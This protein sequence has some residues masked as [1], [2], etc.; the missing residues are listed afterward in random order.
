MYHFKEYVF[1]SGNKVSGYAHQPCSVKTVLPDQDGKREAME[2]LHMGKTDSV[3]TWNS[4][5]LLWIIPFQF[6]VSHW[7]I[8]R[9][10]IWFVLK[11][12]SYFIVVFEEDDSLNSWA[13]AKRLRHDFCIFTQIILWYSEKNSFFIF[14][15]VF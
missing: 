13:I 6:F 14:F 11:M 9:F 12:L 5:R 10:L 1:L 8:F 15:Q 3:L 2:Q 7:S 4:G